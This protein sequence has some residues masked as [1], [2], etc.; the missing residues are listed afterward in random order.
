MQSA[1]FLAQVPAKYL[2][3]PEEREFWD[4]TIRFFGSIQLDASQNETDL[5]NTTS[6]I[7]VF[8]GTVV[9]RIDS[10]NDESTQIEQSTTFNARSVSA[11]ADAIDNDFFMVSNGSTVNLML[12]PTTNAIIKIGNADGSTITISGNGRNINGAATTQ[13]TT[14]YSVLTFY[15]FIENDT[16]VIG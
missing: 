7:D 3:D 11:D 10:G 9:E 13:I 6:V 16:W 2:T 4:Y 12:N 15:Y 14:Q 8:G 1:P 5:T